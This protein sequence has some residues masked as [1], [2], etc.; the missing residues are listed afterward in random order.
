MFSFSL[1]VL[2]I[3]SMCFD[4]KNNLLKKNTRESAAI[5][6]FLTD[7]EIKIQFL[8]SSANS[9]FGC[10]CSRSAS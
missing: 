9:S 10:Y 7:D 5:L 3:I 1:K 4:G 2:S 8:D 6:V